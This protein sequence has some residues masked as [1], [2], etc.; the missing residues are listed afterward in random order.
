MYYIEQESFKNNV[1]LSIT[2]CTF[3]QLSAKDSGGV[4][5]VDNSYLE[6]I[7]I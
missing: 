2:N 1:L 5:Y 7:L 4:M 6:K 3:S